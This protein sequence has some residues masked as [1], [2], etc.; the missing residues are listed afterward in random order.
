MIN[1]LGIVDHD[2]GVVLF[3]PSQNQNSHWLLGN[4]IAPKN[5]FL[6]KKKKRDVAETG[7]EPVT[8]R[9]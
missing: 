2:R 6:K 9:L 8:S 1:D 5:V 7:F 3:F 4:G